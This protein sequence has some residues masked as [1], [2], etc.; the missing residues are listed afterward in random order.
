MGIAEAFFIFAV[1]SAASGMQVSIPQKVYEVA[2][3]DNISLP[4]TFKSQISDISSGSASWNILGSNPDEP[5]SDP[6][7]IYY[8]S[9]GQ[10][11]V[12]SQFTNRA[13]MNPQPYNGQV[14]LSLSN[15]MMSD[16]A[17]F[18]CHVQVPKDMAGSPNAKTRLVVLVAPSVPVCGIQGSPTIGQDIM[19]TCKSSEGSPVPTYTWNSY[20]K[21]NVPRALPP[22][23][24]SKDGVLSLFNI[25]ADTTGYYICKSA[26]KIRAQSCNYTLAVTLPSMSVGSAAIFAGVGLAVV[27]VLG[28]I[29][30]CCCCRRRKEKDTE[31]YDMGETEQP[32]NDSTAKANTVEYRDDERHVTCK[33]GLDVRAEPKENGRDDEHDDNYGGQRDNYDDRRSDYSGRRDNYDDRRSDYS[34][35]RDNYDDRRSDYSGRRDNYDD[36]R[37]DYSGRRDNYD[38][39]YDDRSNRYD[40]RRDRYDD[41]RD[42]YDRRDRYDD[43]RDR[44]G[45]YDDRIDDRNDNHNDQYNDRRNQYDEVS[46]NGHE[47]PPSVPPNKP[48]KMD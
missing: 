43:R 14:D 20:D 35:R 41:R 40:D 46:D 13:S 11:D 9:G 15:I 22:R 27:L 42:D 2:R 30:Y 5:T 1:L 23:A 7:A 10:L 34:G 17:T 3:G 18:E 38:D 36:R 44:R 33:D 6:V 25:S 45:S 19:L 31:D 28:I 37:S 12:S 24:T 39:R 32:L 4:C 16:N 47:R 8:F 29:I 21:N 26:N 48:R